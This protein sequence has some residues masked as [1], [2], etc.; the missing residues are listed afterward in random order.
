MAEAVPL[1]SAPVSAPTLPPTSLIICSRHRAALLAETVASVL[2][3]AEV[4]TELI[5][6]DQSD[7][8]HPILGSLRTERACEIRYVWRPSVGSSLA[9][10]VGT[11][12]AQYEILA[13]LDDDETVTPTWYGTLIRSL[14]DAGPRAVVTG[15]VLAAPEERPDGFVVS[16]HPWEERRVYSGRIGRDVLASGHMAMYRSALEAVG[17]LDERLGPGTGFPGAEDNDL[18]FRLLEA[19]YSLVYEPDSV[20]YHRAWRPRR[21]YVPL[22]W[23]YGRGQGAYYAKHVTINDCHMLHRLANDLGRYLRLLPRR[24]W[25]RQLLELA[26]SSAWILGAFSGALE[27]SWARRR[28]RE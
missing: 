14:L 26:G 23:K 27:W 2:A 13:F 22:F 16:V 19:G 1:S 6:V 18:G 25:R 8:A 4:P 12:I 3:V 7:A 5:V 28:A 17:G 24:L 9:R 10:N 15:R 21:E 20:I 11:A